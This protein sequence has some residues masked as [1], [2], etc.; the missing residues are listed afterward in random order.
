[1]GWRR[2]LPQKRPAAGGEACERISFLLLGSASWERRAC[3][4][5][6]FFVCGKEFIEGIFGDFCGSS[7]KRAVVSFFLRKLAGMEKKVRKES[8]KI[9]VS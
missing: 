9:Q 3:R 6:F 2:I 8:G 4:E 5:V 7:W 1:M